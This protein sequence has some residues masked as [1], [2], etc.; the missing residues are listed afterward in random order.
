MNNALKKRRTHSQTMGPERSLSAP[1]FYMC[2]YARLGGQAALWRENDGEL[3]QP[4]RYC[5]LLAA[6]P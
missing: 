6:R 5:E 1:R 3:G 2:I 4:P